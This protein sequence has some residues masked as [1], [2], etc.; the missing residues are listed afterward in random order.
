MGAL[1]G[2]GA[3]VVPLVGGTVPVEYGVV[4]VVVGY[5][6]VGYVTGG[7]G[8]S[9]VVGY[10]TGGGGGGA[11]EYVTVHGQFVTVSVVADVAVYV[12]L[13]YETVVG[14]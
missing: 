4:A 6:V 3:A 10:V 2:G 12:T 9:S 8:G 14:A 7:G 13:P 1:V 11:V 5:S